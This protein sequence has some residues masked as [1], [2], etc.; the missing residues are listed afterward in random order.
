VTSDGVVLDPAGIPISRFPNYDPDPG[1][2]YVPSVAFDGTNY[3]V[4]WVENR[5]P[6]A[7]NYEVYAARVT[8]EGVVLDPDALQ[9]T[10]GSDPDAARMPSIVFDGT[11]YFVTWRTL[12]SVGSEIRGARV[13]PA[14]INLDAP[15]G[16][17]IG[18]GMYP[19][20]A[21][22]GT[23]YLVV[24]YY[25][26]SGGL[27][28]FGARV[29]RDGTVLDP[30]G[31]PICAA[32]MTQDHPSV[33]FDG[34]NYL[35]VW[36]DRRGG[37][38]R[39]D[40][41]AYGARVSPAGE[42]LDGG[43]FR[44]GEHARSQVPVQV[45]FDGTDY[46]VVWQMDN[47]EPDFRNTD[48]YSRRVSKA[49]TLLDKLAIPVTTAQGNQFGPVVGFAAGRYLVAWNEDFRCAGCVIGQVLQVSKVPYSAP[50]PPAPAPS[51]RGWAVDA[52]PTVNPLYSILAFD[53]T[54]VFVGEHISNLYR[55]DGSGW[56]FEAEVNPSRGWDLWGTAS[57]D[58]WIAAFAG[59]VL[60]YNGGSSD[61]WSVFSTGQILGIWGTDNSNV[62]VVGSE[63][64]YG[65]YGGSSWTV[66]VTGSVGDLA[67]VWGTE[68]TNVYGVGE[69]G[70]IVRYDGA[71]WSRVPDVPTIQRLNG[72]WGSAADDIFAVGDYGT[73][74]HYDGVSWISQESGTTEHLF[75]VW[76][77]GSRDVYAVGH[78]GTI[79]HYDGTAWA[80][81]ESPTTSDLFGVAGTADYVWAVGDTGTILKRPAALT[82]T[83][84]IDLVVGLNL[85]TL[86]L[87]PSTPFTAASLIAN[88]ASQG[89]TV[90]QL[91]V[92][93]EST[94]M[95]MSY[96]PGTSTPNF[97][98]PMGSG[99]FLKVTVG[100]TWQVTGTAPTSGVPINLVTGLNLAG[101]PYSTTPLTA[102]S[103]L[104]GIAAQGG[105]VTQLDTWDE[106]TGMWKS[107]NPGAGTS[108][109]DIVNWRGY[110]LKSTATSTYTP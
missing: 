52:S 39:S 33:A 94:G 46:L 12:I 17:R 55:Y 25:W 74:L 86:P 100:T 73:I 63:G 18:N 98:L 43:G 82:Q 36:N 51:P 89:G 81:E 1:N 75:G 13:S 76:G 77:S 59:F 26:G 38:P 3:M 41:T 65:R 5:D 42:V 57:H 35:V 110:F 71:L 90:T 69:F 68:M 91:D 88:V 103:L 64:Q 7:V 23:N 49:G 50:G 95:W 78:N 96:M 15:T 9:L 92:W 85:V 30:G 106:T 11:N 10:T 66:G 67:D 60:R 44:I 29:A 101:I 20:A 34:T 54:N 61:I 56:M 58:V 47:F 80:A 99:A 28:I 2:Q 79:L 45:G 4:V 107:Y 70:T 102:A 27:D 37:N 109:F 87:A 83:S 97:P 53:S 84:T 22:D 72:V 62:L 14:G 31:F 104:A 105:N 24:W 32:E 48:V 16:F 6:G 19:Y 108:D 93:N 21:F 40:S 8:P